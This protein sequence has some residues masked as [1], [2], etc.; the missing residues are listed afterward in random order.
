MESRTETAG[1]GSDALGL[2]FFNQALV[3]QL[4][5]VVRTPATSD[6]STAVARAFCA[7]LDKTVVE[8]ADRAGL[9]VNHLLFPYLADAIR[10]LDQGV[11]ASR[12]ST[13]QF[14]KASA[15]PWGP[16]PCSTA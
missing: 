9:I 12:R 8:C 16:S 13:R 10:M 5:E 1:R 7:W 15:T 3:M 11:P 14:S 6:H 4:V 2:H